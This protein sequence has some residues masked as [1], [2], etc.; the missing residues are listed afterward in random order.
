[1]RYAVVLAGGSGTRLWP[2]SRTELPKQLMPFIEGK[3][4]LKLA[5]ERLEG[6]VE[7]PR[8]IEGVDP[9]LV[10]SRFRI[11]QYSWFLS[12]TAS[13]ASPSPSMTGF[14][15]PPYMSTT[16]GGHPLRNLWA[17]VAPSTMI[18]I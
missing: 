4:L 15:P 16:M 17:R 3:S 5:F 6:L 7:P 9:A 8:R 11:S 1:L 14:T 2:M 13:S 12:K 18:G 10:S